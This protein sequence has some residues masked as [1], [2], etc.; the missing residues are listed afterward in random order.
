MLVKG[1]GRYGQ[2]TIKAAVHLLTY[3]DLVEY[4]PF[5]DTLRPDAGGAVGFRLPTQWDRILELADDMGI[6]ETHYQLL[7]IAAS[8]AGG[9]KVDL[10]RAT[11]RLDNEQ[12]GRVLEALGIATGLDERRPN[13]VPAWKVPWQAPADTNSEGN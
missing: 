1:A 2:R 4:G 8:L 11:S 5:V 7:Q 6:G 12:A 10:H 9:E 13:W 3:T